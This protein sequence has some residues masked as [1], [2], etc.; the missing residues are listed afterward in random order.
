MS[1]DSTSASR[2]KAFR[3]RLTGQFKRVEAYVTEEEK[4]QIEAVKA[5][6]GVTTD[7]A[8]AGLV[9][10]GLEQYQKEASAVGA[11]SSVSAQSQSCAAPAAPATQ[12]RALSVQDAAMGVSGALSSVNSIGNSTGM[13]S[14]ALSAMGSLGASAG[15][16]AGMA[17]DAA[18]L[19]LAQVRS[20]ST[21]GPVLQANGPAVQEQET[22]T[23]AAS[24]EDNPIARFFQNRKEYSS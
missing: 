11:V 19:Q 2:V 4:R 10:L 15:P 24:R 18:T 16:A 1:K 14:L 23:N 8:V 20:P 5:T 7:V 13:R 21:S 17:L 22:V 6:L 12:A 9:R 3:S